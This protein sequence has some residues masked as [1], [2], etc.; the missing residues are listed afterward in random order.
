[1]NARPFTAHLRRY[2]VWQHRVT[3]LAMALF[4][5]ILGLTGSLLAFKPLLDHEDSHSYVHPGSR[6]K[7]NFA[8][9]ASAAEK[10]YPH[11][12]TA[13]LFAPGDVA[14]VR[15][16]PRTNPQTGKP[17]TDTTEV[18]RMDPWTGASMGAGAMQMGTAPGFYGVVWELHKN[19]TL[20]PW[21]NTF[22]G[23]IAL[24]WA[25]DCLVGLYLTFPLQFKG[26]WRRWAIAW[27]LKLQSGKVRFNYDL[28]RASGLWLWPL[29]FLIAWSGV[30]YNNS[31]IYTRVMKSV[32]P[33]EGDED[34]IHRQTRAKR[35]VP[36]LNW[37]NG[38][39]RCQEEMSKAAKAHGLTIK[40]E[41]V[42]AYISDFGVYSYGVQT[43]A[44]FRFNNP[45]SGVYIDG[46]TGELRELML[47]DLLKPG[48]YLEQVAD[49][50]HLADFYRPAYRW[51]EGVLGIL[52]TALSIT[53][54]IVWWHKRKGRVGR[55]HRRSIVVS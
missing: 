26:F 15:M 17:Y 13:Y 10:A 44:D 49:A 14:S 18:V 22:V 41:R 8:E 51:F 21:G 54:V 43:S 48:N 4:V 34:L 1:M 52:M 47:P 30:K 46:D 24:V 38:Y 2:L 33:Y 31:G 42:L 20:G 55:K 5:V 12:R 45:I 32:L 29:L 36:K 37:A 9:L 7:L 16:E 27:K 19:L 50:L 25:L 6:P 35:E 39:R 28:H 23:Y 3:G 53:G 40:Q 11:A